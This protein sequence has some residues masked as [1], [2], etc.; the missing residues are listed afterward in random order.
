MYHLC[1]FLYLPCSCPTTTAILVTVLPRTKPDP[2]WFGS[3]PV[4]DPLAKGSF[5]YSHL[6]LRPQSSI[7]FH[8]SSF[9]PQRMAKTARVPVKRTARG[10][11]RGFLYTKAWPTTCDISKRAVSTKPRLKLV[12]YSYVWHLTGGYW[13]FSSTFWDII[14][15]V[16]N[17]LNKCSLIGRCL[18]SSAE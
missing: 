12:N 5:S 4:P 6:P 7:R 10:S 8:A 14:C 13:S 18:C 9:P 17:I 1:Y 3:Q 15:H 16:L 2:A 11:K